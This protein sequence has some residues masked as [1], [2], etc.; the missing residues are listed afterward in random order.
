MN[1]PH[2]RPLRRGLALAF[3]AVLPAAY[4]DQVTMKNGDRLSG[5]VLRKSGEVL[6]LNSPYGGELNL[7]WSEVAALE[8][9]APVSLLLADGR[10]V[11][12]R[13][14]PADPAKADTASALAQ[15]A[16]I[17]PT[18]E[19]SG[20]GYSRFGHL[21]LALTQT[22]G[23]SRHDQFHGDGG[24]VWRASAYRVTLAGE[25]NRGH[26]GDIASTSNW[27]ANGRYDRFFKAKEFIYANVSLEEDRFKD[28][29]LRS[30]VGAGYGYQIFE[31]AMTRL[32]LRGG[33]DYVTVDHDLGDDEEYAAFG[34]GVD[35]HHRLQLFPAELFHV[36]DGTRGFGAGRNTVV[37]S[38]TGLRLPLAERLNAT[39]Q[40]N[41]DWE[42][43]PSP[44]RNKTDS[45]LL[46][47]LGYAFR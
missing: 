33:A 37:Q 16:Y 38:R 12:R 42:S 45:T 39:A 34:W 47:G 32:S 13:L 29:G 1:M 11:E 17:N 24:I 41:L 19:E 22:R 21:N 4:A 25:A 40:V 3:F 8:T 18:P 43:R 46:L 23:N 44:G 2:Y 7:R 27:R 5:T 15:I 9:D 6:V 35:F 10:L 28:I 26:D 30:I 14:G 36:H 20:I 31:S